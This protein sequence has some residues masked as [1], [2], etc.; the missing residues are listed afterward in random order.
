LRL[1]GDGDGRG[2]L[3]AG[4]S[5]RGGRGRG[6]GSETR[7]GA[8]EEESSAQSDSSD[9][10]QLDNAVI[11]ANASAPEIESSDD[12]DAH[13]DSFVAVDGPPSAASMG[14]AASFGVPGDLD[15]R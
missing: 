13:G 14:V 9:E 12:E 3:E 1:R 15:G 6:H 7:D 10:S 8:D 4:R 5:G 11:G 2:A